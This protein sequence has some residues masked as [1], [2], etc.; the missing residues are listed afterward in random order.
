[1]EEN[2]KHTPEEIWLLRYHQEYERLPPLGTLPECE[3][4]A[5]YERR[6]AKRL[7]LYAAPNA[8]KPAKPNYDL[9]TARGMEQS[10][11]DMVATQDMLRRDISG[12]LKLLKSWSQNDFREPFPTFESY[13]WKIRLQR[14]REVKESEMVA[15]RKKSSIHSRWN[16][17]IEAYL[18]RSDNEERSV[19]KFAKEWTARHYESLTK[20][21]KNA[22][23]TEFA[24]EATQNKTAI[25]KK[26]VAT[27]VANAIQD[28]KKPGK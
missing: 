5:E 14:F 17:A 15:T 25:A 20:N 1:M 23:M 4:N 7:E 24:P 28:N 22:F 16:D 13:E 2:A 11:K 19:A 10:F 8:P 6:E 18:N 9:K 27:K 12:D 26:A 21:E 3:R